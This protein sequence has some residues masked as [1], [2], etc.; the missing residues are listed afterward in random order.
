MKKNNYRTRWPVTVL[1]SLLLVCFAIGTSCNKDEENKPE[2]KNIQFE[3][4]AEPSSASVETNATGSLS[5]EFDP[6]T[7]ELSYTFNWQDLTGEIG[8]F[9]IHKG[10]GAV[11]INFKD[12]GYATATSG[13]FSGSSVLTEEAW[14]QDL[15]A[16]KLY[17][18][19]HTAKYPAGE[20]IFPFTIQN[21]SGSGNNDNTDN[22]SGE[23]DYD[24]Y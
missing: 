18:Q 10:D 13:T 6:A 15:K 4:T 16:G 5:A 7:G 8:G 23:D 19:I 2:N 12:D 22:G 9:H 3:S 24:I 21:S 1:L 14:I 11:I 17:G 20:L